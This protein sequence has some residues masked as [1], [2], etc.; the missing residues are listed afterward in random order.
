MELNFIEILKNKNTYILIRVSDINRV[1]YIEKEDPCLKIYTKEKH[2]IL[3]NTQVENIFDIYTKIK[4]SICCI[5]TIT[6]NDKSVLIS[7]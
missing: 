7:E 3:N 4:E 1:E 6:K 2:Y 5:S